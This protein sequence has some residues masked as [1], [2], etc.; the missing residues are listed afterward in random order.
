M[1]VI[2]CLSSWITH[3]IVYCRKLKCSVKNCLWYHL[4]G[5]CVWHQAKRAVS[6]GPMKQPLM[7]SSSG[8]NFRV[9]GPLCGEFTGQR[10]IFLTKVSDAELYFF[11]RQLD[12]RLS[13]QSR[14]RWF[15]TPSRSL[16][17]LCNALGIW[18]NNS[19]GYQKIPY[20]NDNNNDN[21]NN[22]NNNNNDNNNKTMGYC[23]GYIVDESQK[24]DNCHHVTFVVTDDILCWYSHNLWYHQE[25]KNVGSV[26]TRYLFIFQDRITGYDSRSIS[27]NTSTCPDP[28]MAQG[29]KF[30]S[31]IRRKFPWSTTSAWLCHLE[32]MRWLGFR[33]PR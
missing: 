3:H 11:D 8:N 32:R 17:R 22:N 27:N 18:V 28:T 29:W 20:W 31:I 6:A 15:E 26:K 16:K 14:R 24:T 33:L 13:K 23:L 12:K 25:W 19:H 1:N 10:W 9:T 4:S 2:N 7:T 30:W 21:N 5:L